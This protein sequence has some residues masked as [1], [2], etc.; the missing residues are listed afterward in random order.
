MDDLLSPR[1][2]AERWGLAVGTL[3]N[4][5][6]AGRGPAFLRLGPNGSAVRYRTSDVLA[7]EAVSRVAGA[8]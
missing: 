5:R 7:Y 6:C 4:L 1:E 3:A 2:L 8:A